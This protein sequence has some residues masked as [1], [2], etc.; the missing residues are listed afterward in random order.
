[1]KRSAARAAAALAV[2]CA[3]STAAADEAP[4]FD[5]LANRLYFF[6]G[7]DIARD[8]AFGWA[9]LVTAPLGA[10]DQDGFRVRVFAGH[11][12][13][14]YRTGAVPTGVN[15]GVDWSGELLVGYR[16]AF[17]STTLVAYVG[18]HAAH[19]SLAFPDPSNP[20]VGNRVGLK[21]LIELHSRA[22]QPLIVTASLGASTVYRAYAMRAA[23]AREMNTVWQIGVE[24]AAFGDARYLETRFGPIARIA[25]SRY[26]LTLAAGILSNSGKG[27]GVYSTFSLYTPF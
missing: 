18:G 16:L 8:S 23:V 24:G 19:H 7:V 11:G 5:A 14:R 15:T 10:L 2:A 26:E 1:M 27:R 9:G 13:Y 20:V 22:F 12:R 6:G 25:L 3:V 4:I 21:A 17:D